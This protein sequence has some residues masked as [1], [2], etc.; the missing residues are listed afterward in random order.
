MIRTASVLR[1]R[2]NVVSL[3]CFVYHYHHK[4]EEQEQEQEQEQGTQPT[5]EQ[6]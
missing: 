3:P 1:K 5:N 2:N 4:E 6:E